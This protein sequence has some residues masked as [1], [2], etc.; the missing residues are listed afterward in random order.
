[1]ILPDP[2]EENGMVMRR[3][4][5]SREVQSAAEIAW[6]VGNKIERLGRNPEKLTTKI[7]FDSGYG[8]SAASTSA[9]VLSQKLILRGLREKFP[10]AHIL[11]EEKPGREDHRSDVINLSRLGEIMTGLTFGVD[12]IDGTSEFKNGLWECALSIGVMQDGIHT[13]GAIYI[14]YIRG[15]VL[16]WGERGK[17]VFLSEAGARPRQ[18]RVSSRRIKEAVVYLGCDFHWLEGFSV[19]EK[20]FAKRVNRTKSIGS[21]VTG[22]AFVAAGRVDALVQPVQKPWDW[23]AGYPLVEEAGGKFQFYRYPEGK[24][25][26][27]PKPDLACYRPDRPNAAFIAGPAA[28]VDFLFETLQNTYSS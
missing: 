4:G 16:L 24:I 18:V 12:P 25:E 2:T 10:K 6:E 7:K 9:D 3:R 11:T 28:I 13:G 5:F 15:G 17:G 14:P 1:M 22:L 20:T 19:F 8:H 21:C 26:P 27:L 23:F